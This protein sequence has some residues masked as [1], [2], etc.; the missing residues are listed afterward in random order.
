MP[1]LV[2]ALAALAVLALP[3]VSRGQAVAQVTT[4]EIDAA[5]VPAYLAGLKK[6]EPIIKKYSSSASMR[7]WHSTVAGPNSNRLSVVV[8]FANLAA[9]AEANRFTSDPEYQKLVR[10][11][12]GMGR[13]IV[14]VSLLSDVTP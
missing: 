9:Y 13:K 4:V 8:E 1:K 14:S 6:I 2:L 11:F 10:E 12:E 5:K 7:V 3:A